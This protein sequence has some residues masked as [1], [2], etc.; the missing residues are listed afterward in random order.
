VV[1]SCSREVHSPIDNFYFSVNGLTKTQLLIT[2]DE[3]AKKNG[4]EKLQE[5]GRNMLPEIKK[6]FLLAVY[7]NEMGYE[8][9]VNNILNKVCFSAS[10]YDI[11]K[12]GS[13]VAISLSKDLNKW[14]VLNYQDKFRLYQNQY[15]K[16][17][18]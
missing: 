2:L 17:A 11:N 5:D 1:T 12:L 9:K 4:F 16:N 6:D 10:T 15:C 8:F 14:L 7:K 18:H 13:E 3:F